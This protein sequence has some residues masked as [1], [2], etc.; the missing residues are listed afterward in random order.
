MD[1]RDNNLG[2][3]NRTAAREHGDR[4]AIIDLSRETAFHVTHLTLDDR[5]TRVA[6]SLTKLGLVPGDRLLLA[7]GNRFEFIEAFFGAM[8]AGVVPIP[9]NVK[10]GADTI[11]FVIE[12]SGCRAAIVEPG[13]HP[14]I[15]EI[16]AETGLM[17]RIA[18]MPEPDGWLSYE[19]TLATAEP[20]NFEPPPIAPRQV[21]FLPYTSGSTG[22][23][24][25][26]LLP[27]DGM[28]WGIATSQLH[29]PMAP[30][31]RALIAGPLFH[32][33]AMRV[34]VKPMLHVGASV[35][36]LPRFEPR[37]FLHALAEHGVTHT[38]G[39]PAMYRMVLA[40]EDLL[41]ELQFPRLKT[42][43]MGSA[44]VGADLIAAVESAFGVPVVEAYGLTEGGGPLREPVDDREV[45]R[46]S[47]GL[48]APEVE[49]K[50]LDENGDENP[51]TGE[52]L[53]RSPAVLVG[54][55]NRSD[56]NSERLVDGWLRTNDIFRRDADGF[57]YFMGRTDDQFSCGGENINPKE[58][59]L[60]L[61]QHQAVIDAVVAP[62]PHELKGLA[63]GALVTVKPGTTTDEDNLKAFC[64][65][66]G[67]RL[68]PSTTGVRGRR[69]ADGRH[70]QD[71]PQGGP[72]H[73]RGFHRRMTRPLVL[74]TGFDPFGDLSV[75]T[76][77]AVV[78]HLAETTF[79]NFALEAQILPTAY[80]RSFATL[81]ARLDPRPDAVL[82]F[83][84]AGS[85]DRISIE[86]RA[87]N[88]RSRER[89]D[90]DGV[91]PS[92]AI[93]DPSAPDTVRTTIDADAL[94]TRLAEDG[95]E[96]H[97]S[98]DAGDYLCNFTYYALLRW[99]GASGVR[100]PAVFVH[101]PDLSGS[102]G[103]PTTDLPRLQHDATRLLDLFAELVLVDPP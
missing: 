79:E 66:H 91:V 86:T 48:V 10:L 69:P 54:Y 85:V 88:R 7:M 6:A 60:L 29:W 18:T 12:D 99:I 34:S 28:L 37:P 55:N 23:P 74:I 32:K 83:G 102:D 59:E 78:E 67:P 35:V 95:I 71:R 77:Q 4:P 1:P 57:F 73:D 2:Y 68:C 46:G 15:E 9:L 58:V 47:C 94:L 22:R 92:D 38:G 63:P 42:L 30:D 25:G 52:L 19:E 26:V 16:V 62:I 56:L 53:V 84:V 5:M 87:A 64:L 72:A 14:Q 31:D 50:M 81:E 39:V 8:R 24:K 103:A 43:E 76:S 97:L 21:A 61:V 27:H 101:V 70:G 36:I 45:P 89:P 40:E 98:D 80:G 33:N 17:P 100:L 20:T 44:V 65:E 96:A 11:R 41:A 90:N 13:C 82:M 49:V 51:E 93:I 3:F 75:N